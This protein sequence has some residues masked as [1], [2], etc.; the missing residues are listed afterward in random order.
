M[1]RTM[2]T[3]LA[4]LALTLLTIP[5]LAEETWPQPYTGNMVGTWCF[6]GGGEVNG[7]GFR[8]N[9]DGT[10]C[11][12]DIVDY[13]QVPPVLM[14][15]EEPST[16]TWEIAQEDG[17]QVLHERLANGLEVSYPVERWSDDGRIHLPAGD[18]GGF[19]M[20]YL[21][22]SAAAY[23]AAQTERSAFDGMLAD[24]L[25]SSMQ[26]KLTQ[27]GLNAYEIVLRQVDGAWCICVGCFDAESEQ[28]LLF[29]LT[30]ESVGVYVDSWVSVW[31]DEVTLQP[32]LM[33]S[34]PE[35]CYRLMAGIIESNRDLAE[36]AAESSTPTREPLALTAVRGDFARN[37]SFAVYESLRG[38]EPRRAG[39]GKAK[40]STNGEISVYGQ[41]MGA[42]LVEYEI[43]ADRHRIGWIE[44]EMADAP[45]LDFTDVYGLCLCGVVTASV[46][47]TD[48]PL[49]SGESIAVMAGGNSVHVLGRLD[50]W[51]L[52]EGFIG[53]D[54]R[55]GFVPA[56]AVDMQSGYTADTHYVIDHAGKYTEEDIHA[57]MDALCAA[58]RAE[59][60]GSALLE[61]RYVDADNA[62]PN[63]W[64]RTDGMEDILFYTDLSSMELWD[65]EIAGRL[66]KDYLFI[67]YRE[68]GGEWVVRN[69][70]YT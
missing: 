34:T 18:G 64:W 28:E 58:F 52:V 35:D 3:V 38:E 66:A 5:A 63:R 2:R 33:P 20:P 62:D 42:L 7:D 41:W 11:F 65:F 54:V 39:N 22:D 37:Q 50:D 56:S 27:Q 68:P 30:E 17:Y 12:L 45:E 67:L 51:L 59:W 55:M 61:I 60:A 31:D 46:S 25:D 29:R 9:A 6:V 48:D 14:E 23:L 40:V 16:F 10:G 69:W 4:L 44:A 36:Q 15:T 32:W 13:D 26:A 57:A 47:L 24:Y 53:D 49:F 8:L 70:G 21:N 19:Y 1:M 43:S